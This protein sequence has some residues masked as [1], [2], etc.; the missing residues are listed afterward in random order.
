MVPG[1]S[2]FV[3][4]GQIE[5]AGHDVEEAA[6]VRQRPVAVRDSFRDPHEKVLPVAGH[7]DL[8]PEI[9]GR[10]LPDVQQDELRLVRVR[11]EPDVLL[12]Q[13]VVQSLDV[14]LGVHDREI[15]LGHG[16]VV[17]ERRERFRPGM[18][19]PRPVDLLEEPAV[20]DEAGQ[21]VDLDPGDRPWL[22]VRL[23]PPD[24]LGANRVHGE[25]GGRG[26]AH[27]ISSWARILARRGVLRFLRAMLERIV[28]VSSGKGGV[29]KTTV[30]V[31]LALSLSRYAPTILV[32]LDT[33][34]SSVRNSIGVP[35]SHD[36]Y[37]FFRK[38]R[39]LSDCITQLP[40]AWDPAGL[41]RNFGFVA[42]P[43]HLI[44]EITNFNEEKKRTLSEAINALPATWVVLDMKAG[45]DAH[46][47]DFLP[48]AN[49]GILVF[50]P[51]LPSATLAASDIVKAILFRKLRIVF[52]PHSPFFDGVAEPGK[53]TR[54]VNELL[55]QVE[56]V[57]ETALPNLDAFLADLATSLGPHPL[58]HRLTRTI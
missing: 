51:H 14:V 53:M 36:L 34:T 41:Y 24:E 56:D 18:V 15:D 7:Q 11:A 32:D 40:D 46:V 52:A 44:E 16:E 57:Y 54:L 21:P 55:D 5:R 33:G 50:T 6:W 22:L 2:P 27:R 29:G 38:G 19:C 49:S 12:L 3:G 9:G 31:N 35:V 58:L 30:A 47:I 4:V 13:V 20:V 39:P 42:G 17:E 48:Y 45:V 28:P 37:H 10:V 1:D 25:L 8:R 23:R 43:M 26:I